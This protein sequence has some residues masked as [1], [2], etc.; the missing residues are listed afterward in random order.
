LEEDGVDSKGTEVYSSLVT[1]TF[2]EG[3]DGEPKVV[4]SSKLSSLKQLTT[5]GEKRT[6]KLSSFNLGENEEYSI[7]KS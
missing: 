6:S 4:K 5:S 7:G 1:T 3:G 2:R